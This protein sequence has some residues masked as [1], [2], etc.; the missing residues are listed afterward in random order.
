MQDLEKHLRTFIQRANQP[1]I[2]SFIPIG[3]LSM[4]LAI[5]G[6]HGVPAGRIIQV[7]G[8]PSS[9]K[10]TLMLDTIRQYQ[11][12]YPGQ[13]PIYV[14][15]ERSFSADYAGAMG[16]DLEDLYIVRP[17]TTEQG[18]AVAEACVRN[19][20]TKLVI[21]DSIA[22]ATPSSEVEKSIEDSPKMASNAGLVTRFVNRINPLLD[23]N[24]VMLIVVNQMR[25]NFSTMSPET[26]IPY[27]GLA[28]QFYAAV[29]ILLQAIKNEDDKMT[30]QA[31]IRKNKVGAP[32]TRVQYR[33][34]YGVGIRHD[35]DILEAGVEAG[36]I[37]RS[38][39][40]MQYNHNGEDFRAQGIDKAAQSF[41][42]DRIREQLIA[43]ALV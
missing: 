20:S 38:G 33:I 21:V 2:H 12:Q 7:F 9:G 15:Y 29:N 24:D 17:D 10:S 8:K 5:H 23:N 1:R 6:P 32:R 35:L 3:P 36:M 19:R 16:I 42:I 13:A 14:D 28:L 40:W 37:T 22:A 11:Q 4:N 26:E 43:R 30:V 41:P 34:D 31:F 39:S 18:M 27:G 25:K